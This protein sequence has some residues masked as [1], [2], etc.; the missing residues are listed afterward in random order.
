M[1][2]PAY[3]QIVG[4]FNQTTV[5]LQANDYGGELDPHGADLLGNPLGG[6]FYSTGFESGNNS[7]YVQTQ[8]WNN[9]VGSGQFCLKLCDPSYSTN[10]NY[11]QK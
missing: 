10:M 3:I 11:C 7:T 5:G 4:F 8:S 6:L 2:T 9:F 1:K